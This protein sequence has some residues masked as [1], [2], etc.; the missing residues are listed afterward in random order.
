MNRKA[1]GLAFVLF[2]TVAVGCGGGS[3]TPYKEAG[4]D[5]DAKPDKVVETGAPEVAAPMAGDG[6]KLLLPGSAT[7][8][9]SGPDSC[10]SQTPAPGDRWCAF[11]KPSSRL[12]FDELWVINV[13]KASAGTA[14]KCDT[15]DENCLRLTS[16][17]FSD[18]DAGFRIHGFDGDTLIYHAELGPTAVDSFVGPI[19]A[20]RP[21][22]TGGHKLTSDTGVVCSGHP[23]AA[24][25][26]CFEGRDESV[27][28]QLSYE[29]HAGVLSANDTAPLPKVDSLII[30]VRGD[31]DGTRKFQ[32]D[33]SDDGKWVGW[34]ARQMPT[35]PEVLK[36]Q[37][38]GDNASRVTVASDVTRWS[39]SPDAAKWYWL[40]KFNYD[41]NG[42][43][44]GTLESAN[45]P[46]GDAVATLAMGVGDYSAAGTKGLLLRTGEAQFV[47]E[48]KLMADRDA[49]S[50]LKTFDKGVLGVL[51]QSPDGTK[52]VYAKDATLDPLVDLYIASSTAATPCTLA[53]ETIA[54]P[55]ATFVSNGSMLAWARFNELALEIEGLYTTV[56]D[57]RSR[58]FSTNIASWQSV[59][60]EGFVYQDD[61]DVDGADEATLNYTKVANGLLTTPGT[62]IQTRATSVYSPLLPALAS[63]VYSVQTHGTG[64]GLYINTK[65]PFTTSTGA[66]PSDGGTDTA[67][68]TPDAAADVASDAAAEAGSDAGTDAAS[69]AATSD[70]P[71]PT[72]DAGTDS[73]PADT[74]S[75]S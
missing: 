56:E 37:K 24:V 28:D 7:L 61:F 63:V 20:W 29:L 64:D 50:T 39:I 36:A 30:A 60:D 23:K 65:L 59:S 35:G 41:P 15:T 26:L 68:P 2:G 13:T 10:T 6:S 40:K 54:E 71:A 75:G 67:A 5:F 53:S 38:V 49:P 66:P 3:Q 57:C 55:A 9:G 27:T 69:D 62:K 43:E 33:L 52:A 19:Y 44:S 32:A 14:I 12:G 74:G 34:S 58:K 72:A 22:W 1:P 47:G 11:S 25:A 45:F 48:L 42:A 31:A 18:P 8:I 46:M 17:L 21:G 4:V 51:Q 70:A 16:G 73:A